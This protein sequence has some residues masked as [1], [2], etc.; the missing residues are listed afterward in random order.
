[1]EKIDWHKLQAKWQKKWQIAQLGKAKV[2]NTKEKFM[3]IFAYPGVSG[4]LHV[5]HM[6]GFSYTDAICRLERMKGKEVLYPV[7][8][9]ASGNQAF[10]FANKVKNKDETW[11]DYL[12][13]N[14]CPKNKLKDLE[15]PYKVIDYF[16]EVYVNDYWKKFGFLADW[17]R[18]TSTTYPD[19]EKFIQWQFK[20][21]HDKDLLT[22]K[23]YFATAC[24]NCGPVA[25][26]PSETDI[27]KGGNAEKNEYTLL[28]FKL[29][30][31]ENGNDNSKTDYL[32]AATLRPETVYGQTNLWINPEAEYVRVQVEG[33]NWIMSRE[34]AEKLS[35]QIDDVILKEDVDPK[36]LLG[37]YALAPGVERE[38][39][40]LPA[41]FCN[42]KVGSG[43]VTSVPSDAPYDYVALRTLKD[44]K[45]K[46]I[47]KK[48]GIKPHIVEEIKLIPIIK[49]EGFGNFPAKEIVERMKISSLDDKE[50]LEEATKEIYKVGFHT[51]KMM[52][53]CGTYAEMRVTEAKEAVK[54]KLIEDGK[55]N[56]FHDL[57]EEVVCRCGKKVIIKRIDDQWFIKYSDPE[58]TERSKEQ[59]QEMNIYPQEYKDQMPGV[60]DWFSD[61]A[62]ARLG[63]WMGSKFP[64][65]DRWTVEPISD[66]TLYPAYYIVSKFVNNKQLNVEDLTE[67][68]F[69]YVFLKKDLKSKEKAEI[70]EKFG[71]EKL[72]IWIKVQEEFEYFYP[73]DINLGGKEHKTVHFPVFLMNHVAILNENKWPRG[74]FVNWW[75]TGKGSKISK[76]KGGAEPIPEAIEKFGVDAM[77]LYYAHIGSP[78]VDV[79]WDEEIV[80]NYKQCLEKVHLLFDELTKETK[81]SKTIIDNWLESE[82]NKTVKKVNHSLEKYN[83]RD[84]ASETYHYIPELFRWYLR[85]GGKNRDLIRSLLLE[86]TKLMCP[87]TP[88]IAEELAE[89]F[90]LKKDQDDFI[91]SADWPQVDESKISFAA[92]GGEELVKNTMDGMRNVL[93]LAK[94]EKANK[95]TV[96][97]S[98]T[99]Q[100]E[101]FKIVQSEI[102]VTRNMGE[103]IKKVMAEEGM[104][105]KGK[106]ISKIIAMLMKDPSKMP[107]HITNQENELEVMNSAKGFLEEEFNAKVEI[108][109]AED[110]GETKA[111]QAMP[112][113]VGILVE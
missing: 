19:Y 106:E 77:R 64:F 76:S 23:P 37:Q 1:M 73:L 68:F 101:L 54:L 17:D 34:A 11:I 111:K 86:W 63:N 82:F 5:G 31:N 38:I 14:G 79:V 29:H 52:E 103:I 71:K 108:I 107:Q 97:I 93:K 43:I 109:I 98:Q 91:S 40:I 92:E 99:W 46:V 22:Q 48:Y 24:I 58:L 65:D 113:K 100:Y 57:S 9:H 41:T 59:V 90:K 102:K 66:S 47:L 6:R 56:L 13:K 2:D 85:R 78:H 45:D 83:L 49:S 36:K 16:N 4:Y 53:H 80:F 67:Q 112:G 33:E 81:N 26:D 110:S 51:G 12:L 89:E 8:T 72:D 18:F 60:L 61:R 21:L 42:S 7:G 105:A 62:C 50:K 96:F 20:K 70:V 10:A 84:H 30:D 44:D 27:S 94:L 95:F 32:V 15:D 75:V 88:H 55:A 69:D 3:M 87:I 25:V 28:K 35:Y 74:I 104:Q 39:P